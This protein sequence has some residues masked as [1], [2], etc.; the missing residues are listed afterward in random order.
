V[1]QILAGMG[2]TL[3]LLL[4]AALAAGNYDGTWTGTVEAASAR[5][6][7]GTIAMHILGNDIAG[8]FGLGGARVPFRGTV[9]DDGS[10][11]ASYNY[12][13][14][15]VSGSLAGKITG[16]NF[17]GKLESIYQTT[18]SDCVRNVTAKRA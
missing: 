12:P 6:P 3:V 1:R 14:H 8:A 7:S 18:G 9:A 4:G 15:S 5:C 17:T 2:A 16:G 13:S 10:V 11:T